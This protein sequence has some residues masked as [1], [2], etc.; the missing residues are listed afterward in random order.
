MIE[1]V[2]KSAY[3]CYEMLKFTEN[4]TLCEKFLVTRY[5]ACRNQAHKKGGVGKIFIA[6]FST[7][8]FLFIYTYFI[9]YFLLFI[10]KKDKESFSIKNFNTF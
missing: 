8:K 5:S 3:G 9:K 10:E 1:R 6:I 2:T 4:V 7:I